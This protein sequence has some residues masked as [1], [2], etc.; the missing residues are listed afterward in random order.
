MI[1]IYYWPD[2]TWCYEEDRSFVLSFM[3]D[4]YGSVEVPEAAEEEEIFRAIK[5]ANNFPNKLR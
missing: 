3:S 1:K 2:G 5:A 4:D